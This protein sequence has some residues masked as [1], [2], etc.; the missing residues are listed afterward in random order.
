MTI[1]NH[2]IEFN[3]MKE[4]SC[5]HLPDQSNARCEREITW[6]RDPLT[7]DVSLISE[8][9]LH[10]AEILFGVTDF[11]FLR[12]TAEESR[13][14]CLFCPEKVEEVTPTYPSDFIPQGRLKSDKTILFPNIFPLSGI[15]AVLTWPQKHFVLMENMTLEDLTDLLIMA[16]KFIRRVDTVYPDI[17][18]ISINAN[19]LPPAG[20][21][22]LHPHFQIVGGRHSP[23]LVRRHIDCSRS[24]YKSN[25]SSYWD[26]LVAVERSQKERWI[27]A[28]GNWSW[29]ASYA[30]QGSNEICA[31]NHTTRT[32]FQMS[33][34]DICTLVKGM[35]QVLTYW[36]N[37]GYSTFNFSL[38]GD[39]KYKDEGDMRC[40]AKM[41]TRQNFRPMYRT[42]DYFIQKMLGAELVIVPP[43][44]IASDLRKIFNE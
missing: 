7:G 4:T 5:F 8:G 10:K 22:I 28:P 25:G 9:L 43:E 19:H 11:K 39:L 26:D 40:I 6:R 37:R 1:S 30:P 44:A 33:N 3:E 24:Y 42:D 36:G 2:G 21:S 23:A 13:E 20:A 35:K 17:G 16:M 12:K 38:Y 31:I 34:E 18:F 14:N 29:L 27:A 41:I 15:H 32:L